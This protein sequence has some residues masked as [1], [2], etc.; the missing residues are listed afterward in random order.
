M[1]KKQLILSA[2]FSVLTGLLLWFMFC[3]PPTLFN[4]P[5]SMVLLD[6][7]RQILGAQIAG[8]QQWRF[9]YNRSVADKYRKCLICFEDKRFY[10]HPGVD[11]IAMIRAMGQ[12]I[13]D[14]EITSGGSTLTMQ[15][16]RLE[17]KGK[18]RSFGEKLLEAFMAL[19]L[20]IEYSK[21]EILALYTSNAP[22]GGNIVGLDAAS[23]RYFGRPPDQLSWAESAML[24]VLPNSPSLMHTGKNRDLLLAKRNRLLVKMYDNGIIDSMTMALAVD[25]DIPDHPYPYPSMARHLTGRAANEIP[26]SRRT[27]PM[28]STIDKNIQERVMQIA[29]SHQKSLVSNE[30]G[31]VAVLV[32]D[33]ETGKTLAYAGNITDSSNYVYSPWVDMIMAPRSSGSILKPFLY[34]ALLSSGELLPNS[35]VPDIPMRIGG[36]APENFDKEYSGAVHA[37]QALARSLNVPAVLM[38]KDYG[39]ARFKYLLGD[40]GLTTIRRSAGD[41]GLSLILGGA[42]TRL[43]E[44]CGVYSSMARVL[45]HYTRYNSRYFSHDWRKPYY[46]KDDEK[47]Y[48]YSI[49]SGRNFGILGAA[50]IWFTF[51]AM[52]E[53]ERPEDQ[54]IWQLF[55]SR[56]QIA[57]K[58]G[59]SFGFRDAW[60]IGITPRFVVGVWVGNAQGN[61]R[62]G[63]IG[64]KAAAPVMFDVFRSLPAYENWFEIP[65]D[66]MTEAA[67]CRESGFLASEICP[68]ADTSLIPSLGTRFSVCPYHKLIFL[69]SEGL[70]RVFASCYPVA[71]MQQASWFVLPPTMEWYYKTSHPDYQ[72]LP[73]LLAGCSETGAASDDIMDVVYPAN[74]SQIFIPRT[75]SGEKGKTVFEVTHR[76]P[77][78]TLYWHIDDQFVGTT[79]PPHKMAFYIEA[80]A[81]KLTLVDSE[82]NRISRKFTILGERP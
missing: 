54:G 35:L 20:E 76:N 74:L 43:W 17:R 39:V 14:G 61:G 22:F 49:E 28:I 69:D 26:D 13:S 41:Y 16:I 32:L 68:H 19:R 52:L 50:S 80:G 63:I 1:N 18:S 4:N 3:I 66:D 5:V 38:L 42:E 55:D 31:N 71:E 25:E 77:K 40:M 29:L 47:Q 11:P 36:F 30:I 70:N 10:Q 8:D 21:D 57:W 7:N 46:L 9:P 48:D 72:S 51:Q 59:T 73:P 24:A 81:H 75:M 6:S 44:L 15:V 60:A 12:N 78:T 45:M 23:W 56:Q 62:P 34:A 27:G 65:Y 67:V 58:T 33:T 82:G 2:L 79:V 64:V 37:D 53:P